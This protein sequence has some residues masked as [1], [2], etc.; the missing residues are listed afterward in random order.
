MLCYETISSQM[1]SL[2]RRLSVEPLLSGTRLVGGTALALQ[3]GHRTS[4]DLDFFGVEARVGALEL[5]A[6]FRH[7][8]QFEITEESEHI[9]IYLVDGIKVDFVSHPYDW[10]EDPFIVEP[11]RLA[12]PFDIAAMKLMAIINRGTRK[13]FIDLAVLF[14][15]FSLEEMVAGFKKKYGKHSVFALYKSLLYFD[16]AEDDPMP[17]MCNELTWEDAQQKVVSAVKKLE[18]I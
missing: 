17:V 11:I 16:D 13:D 1:L 4:V 12:T 3:Y 6:L 7:Y 18:Q 9:H 14:D 5:Q 10:L 2:L 15:H 8:E